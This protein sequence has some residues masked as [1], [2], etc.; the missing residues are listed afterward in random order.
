MYNRIYSKYK[1]ATSLE[2]GKNILINELKTPIEEV[3]VNSF[4]GCLQGHKATIKGHKVFFPK[5]MKN[6]TRSEYK[7]LNKIRS[8]FFR[9]GLVMPT[10]HTMYS[11]YFSADILDK[12]KNKE[13]AVSTYLNGMYSTE[14]MAAF[15]IGV[16]RKKVIAP[17]YEQIL[18]SI[19]AYYAGLY[20]AAIITLIPCIEGI[21]RNIGSLVGER[22]QSEVKTKKF[23]EILGKVGLHVMKSRVLSNYDWFPEEDV[24]ELLDNFDEQVHIIKNVMYY[25]KTSVLSFIVVE[26][27][28][29]VK[30]RCT[31]SRDRVA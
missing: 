16:Y 31:G 14:S 15:C 17:F 1:K 18:E 23:L 12:A 2:A 20:K 6:S 8:I 24:L 26:S 9:V 10:Y 30:A 29:Y 7:D 11:L 27:T 4:F 28:A 3:T 25:I 22:C 13:E 21:I 19:Q 5:C